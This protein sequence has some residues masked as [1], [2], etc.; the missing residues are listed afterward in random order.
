MSTGAAAKL[1]MD[2]ETV[3]ASFRAETFADNTKGT[4]A[5]HR[6]SYFEFCAELCVPP[7]PASQ[8][9]IAIF[10]VYLARR[11]KSSSVLQSLNI[12]RIIHLEAGLNNP[13]KDNWYISSTL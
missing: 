2:F 4:Y 13:L 6:N 8:E 10:A 11:L 1:V 7:V 5:A 12:V 3:V 9:T